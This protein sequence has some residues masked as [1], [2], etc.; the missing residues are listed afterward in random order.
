MTNKIDIDETLDKVL[1]QEQFTKDDLI[2]L[3]SLK[4]QE[5]LEK[6]YKR[7]YQIKEKYIG[8]KAYYRGLIEF[9]NKC[10]K[11]CYYCGIR[12]SNKDTERFDMTMSEIIEMAK[13]AYDNNYGSI[14]LQSGERQDP[15]FTDFV[16]EAI[17]KI[18]EVSNGELGLTLCLGEQT[19]ETYRR[20]FAGGGHR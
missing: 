17:I 19:E 12:R 9:S 1:G 14:T 18:K 4:K 11:D 10:I 16:E 15:E 13:W 8:K 7:A 3:M 20:L 2:Y 5:D 6:L